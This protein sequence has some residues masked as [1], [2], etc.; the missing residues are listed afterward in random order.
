MALRIAK[1]ATAVAVFSAIVALPPTVL[2][3]GEEPASPEE[4]A[5]AIRAHA[6]ESYDAAVKPADGQEGLG[7]PDG[8]QAAP[9]PVGTLDSSPERV[10][11]TNARAD[12]ARHGA[13]NHPV[14]GRQALLAS[15]VTNHGISGQA[16]VW[17]VQIT[18]SDNAVESLS[19]VDGTL[20]PGE[21]LGLE[22]FWIPA[23]A[24]DY[25]AAFFVWEGIANP[26]A[27]SYPA[28]L[29]FT[30][31]EEPPE[32]AT[33]KRITIEVGEPVDGRGLLPITTTE[34]TETAGRL[35]SV[36]DWNFL[37]LNHGEWGPFGGRLG[38]DVLPQEHSYHDFSGKKDGMQV[39]I[40]AA[41]LRND[42]L[43][44]YP[45]DCR[46]TPIEILSAL[47]V[48]IEIP[49]NLSSVSVTA[50]DAGLLPVGGLYKLEFASFFDHH[51]QL[52]E[53]ARVVHSE[54][55]VCSVDADGF[56]TG[57]YDVVV[58]RLEPPA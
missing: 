2:S 7:G 20:G 3:A 39:E 27:L 12:D 5:A 25:R 23:K 45:A 31:F 22:T 19:W 36:T 29:G 40:E 30:V 1:I 33:S 43:L 49:E 44:S 50:S 13:A 55:V 51:I 41:F 11:V 8:S 10:S 17:I 4:E 48:T 52:P 34:T 16:F 21:A 18:G 14:V 15:D 57:L 46:G 42:I 35:G 6:G 53:N 28:E 38:W 54:R 56:P 26:A 37:P 47:P 58:F 9:P 24:G 32:S